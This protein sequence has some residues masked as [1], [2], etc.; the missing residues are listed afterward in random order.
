MGPAAPV[1]GADGRAASVSSYAPLQMAPIVMGPQ[2]ST[3]ETQQASVEFEMAST[4][5][6][7]QDVPSVS[8]KAVSGRRRKTDAEMTA[9]K[10]TRAVQTTTDMMTTQRLH[11]IKSS[12][13]RPLIV[14]DGIPEVTM[15][16][17]RILR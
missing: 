2:V 7:R 15:I 8:A 5:F 13:A 17:N 14:N 4:L 6:E 16:W 3:K 9:L 10:S 12:G 11:K 1:S